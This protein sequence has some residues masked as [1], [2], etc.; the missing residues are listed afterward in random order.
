MYG[1]G[2]VFLLLVNIVVWVDSCLRVYAPAVT[3]FSVILFVVIA[4]AEE[5]DPPNCV[6]QEGVE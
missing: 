6:D 5:E 3:F 4:A 2:G 1:A